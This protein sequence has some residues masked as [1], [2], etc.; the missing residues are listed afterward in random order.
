MCI[1][2]RAQ[3]NNISFV[4]SSSFRKAE[5]CRKSASSLSGLQI[6]HGMAIVKTEI[7]EGL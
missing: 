2:P 3:D 5:L 1:H 7:D 4:S 6:D